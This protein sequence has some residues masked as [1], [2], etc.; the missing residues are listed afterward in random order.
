MG[1]FSTPVLLLAFVAGAAATWVAGLLLSKTTDALDDRLHLGE[2]LGGMILLAIAG[3]LPEVAITVTGALQGHLDIV[4]GNLIG[5]IAVQTAVLVICDLVVEGDHPLSSLVGSLMPVLEAVL[6]VS[7]VSLVLMGALLPESVAVAG[8]SPV[9]V[10]IVLAWALGM[11]VLNRVR[12]A[13]RWRVKAPGS[14]P[15]RPHRR[16][17]HPTAP[18]PFAHASNRRVALV[19]A[20]ASAVTLIAGAALEMSG[21]ELAARANMSGVVFGATVL[22]LASA[23]PEI[24]TGVAAVRLGDNELVMGDIFGGNAFQVCLFL[25][26]DLLAGQPV[27]PFAGAAN[28]WLGG[29]GI[30]LTTV[31]ATGIV[32]RPQRRFARLGPDSIAVLVLLALGLAGL[33]VI[34]K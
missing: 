6:V 24:S 22:A 16:I 20:A 25:L 34:A 13:P 5:G 21:S 28:S 2:A 4:A 30:V 9:S 26:A 32:V 23:L 18:R 3:S 1:S 27:L 33:A 7:V 11:L 14:S 29:L 15:G 10:L 31:Y 19:F 12:R 8:V 17:P